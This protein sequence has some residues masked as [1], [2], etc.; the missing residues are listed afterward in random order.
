MF[1][2]F[3]EQVGTGRDRDYGLGLEE[4]ADPEL[5]EAVAWVEVSLKGRI[6]EREIVGRR[7]DLK[8]LTGMMAEVPP[9]QVLAGQTVP[10]VA[11]SPTHT[12]PFL[13][14]DT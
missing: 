9:R 5:E 13:G 7:G 4:T 1:R 10:H 6:A 14:V 2:W 3:L 8:G 12:P 11:K